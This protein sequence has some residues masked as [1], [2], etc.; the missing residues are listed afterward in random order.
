MCVC[1]CA[2]VIYLT[3]LSIT[4]VKEKW[5]WS[6][7]G[8]LVTRTDQSTRIKTCTSV[9]RSNAHPT[10]VALGFSLG[11]C[12]GLPANDRLRHGT[13]R[14]N[15]TIFYVSL[16]K[17]EISGVKKKHQ[18]YHGGDLSTIMSSNVWWLPVAPCMVLLCGI[19]LH[20]CGTVYR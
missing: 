16:S 13:A 14:I 19:M 15:G 5:V 11:V 18:P 7:A 3:T 2:C 12:D 9:T 17:C 8:M 10:L 6:T 20:V 4:K 1:V